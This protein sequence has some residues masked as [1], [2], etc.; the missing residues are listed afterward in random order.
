MTAGDLINTSLRILGTLS[1]GET[2]SAAE[3]TDGLNTLNRLIDSWS[4]ENLLIPNK[5]REVFALV[6]NQQTYTMGTGGNF[7]TPRAQRIE[8]TIIQL[9]TNS[10]VLELPMKMLTK[11]EYASII[12]K[13]NTS[14]FPIYMYNDHA[15]PLDSINVWP[16]PTSSANNIV[17]YSWKPL[18][19][20]STLTTALSLPPGYQR[21]LSFALAIDLSSEYGRAVTQIVADMAIESKAAIKRIN[22]RAPLLQV[23]D[24][25]RANPS[26]FNWYTG[27][28]Q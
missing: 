4:N 21:A 2:A 26:I 20:L 22:H 5:V 17:L 13:T 15:Y 3:S 24:A 9:A 7:N 12:L 6:A 11:D 18:A 25:L 1:S 10:P 23:D 16:V 28:P 8:N 14:A 19:I 27:E